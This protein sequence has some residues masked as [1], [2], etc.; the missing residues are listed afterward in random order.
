MEV[1]KTINALFDKKKEKEDIERKTRISWEWADGLVSRI[2]E[3]HANPEKK[4]VRQGNVAE[5]LDNLYSLIKSLPFSSE[6]FANDISQLVQQVKTTHA[7]SYLF[8]DGQSA[9]F[10]ALI[11][12]TM[13]AKKYIFST[14]FFPMAIVG[15]QD[16]YGQAIT[17]RVLG[18]PVK[19]VNALQGYT[20][21][22]SANNIDKLKDIDR[23]FA[24]FLGAN[25][26]LHVTRK[27]N[28]FELVIIDNEEVFV[29]FYGAGQVI[30]STLHIVGEELASRFLNI[31]ERL[32]PVNDPDVLS[33]EFRDMKQ[34]NVADARNK[35]EDMF[36]G[37]D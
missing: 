25:F 17:S 22:I 5:S 34:V 10:S 28:S 20:R 29:H 26:T 14:R 23:Y 19:G 13:R 12:A 16:D 2:V 21:I 1:L 27:T 15:N 18:D 32:H 4:S 3:K 7:G 36:K 6:A 11:A 37:C 24:D 35:L 30:N 33:I 31:Y 9:A 8:I